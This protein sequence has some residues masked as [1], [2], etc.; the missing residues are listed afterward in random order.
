MCKG[1]NLV[2]FLDLGF[3]PPA[4]QFLRSDQLNEPETY[5]PLKV[6]M[7]EDCGLAQI[8][9]KVDPEVLYQ[10][11]YPY[12]SS[13]TRTGQAHWSEFAGTVSGRLGLGGDDLVIDI[14]SNVGVLL[15]AFRSNG[16]RILGVD[17]A[18]NIAKI[19]NDR[20]V[21]TVN[22]FFSER[23]AR[24]IV[25]DKGQATVITGTNVFA[26]IDDLDD[27]MAG[28]DALLDDRGYFVVEAPYFQHLLNNL[29]YD[30]IYHE[31]L[32]YLSVKPMKM[33]FERFG[34]EVVNIEQ[35]DIHGGAFRVYVTRRGNAKPAP[36]VDELMRHEE[37]MGM[38]SP[39]TLGEFSKSVSKNRDQLNWLLRRLKHEGNRVAGVSAPA[40]GMTLLNY[41]GIGVDTLDFI[42]EKSRLKIGRFTP[43][44]HIPVVP[45]EELLRQK[46]DY[47]L[48]LAW[49]F[50]E[51]IME[52][53]KAYRDAGGKFIIPIPH[54][55]IVG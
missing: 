29:E 21:E 30:T 7:C 54:P 51:E 4:D 41:C 53:L 31:H 43:G 42:T 46:P 38:H 14:G 12:E 40:K 36:V 26:H 3:T 17:P 15:D 47:A 2:Q 35:R 9:Y 39:E 37:D 28:V 33:F 55:Q 25:G 45:D 1:G 49:N 5:Y 34:M 44:K 16:T 23:V 10:R 11:D 24:E 48:L 8:N 22:E 13:L 18:G 20:G 27:V 52:N 6:M 19:A 32:S 50:A